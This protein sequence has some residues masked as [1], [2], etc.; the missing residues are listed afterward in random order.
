MIHAVG[1]FE[2]NASSRTFKPRISASDPATIYCRATESHVSMAHSTDRR[3][4]WDTVVVLSTSLQR[5]C[6]SSQPVRGTAGCFALSPDDM[7]KI[8]SRSN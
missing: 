6:P 7:L 5:S 8:A 2:P 4:R 1:L 3:Y